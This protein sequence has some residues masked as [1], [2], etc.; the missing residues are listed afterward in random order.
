MVSSPNEHSA[1]C[2]SEL[3]KLGSRQTR[4]SLPLIRSCK[5]SGSRARTSLSRTAAREMAA[6]ARTTSLSR[7]TAQTETATRRAPNCST[8]PRGRFQKKSSTGVRAYF[9]PDSPS[10]ASSAKIKKKNLKIVTDN[11]ILVHPSTYR[12][13]EPALYSD[14]S[15]FRSDK[16]FQNF[17]LDLSAGSQTRSIRNNSPQDSYQR[18]IYSNRFVIGQVALE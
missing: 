6:K 3:C 4:K 8:Q 5:D 1:S 13:A 12:V 14:G 7:R 10:L 18:E 2:R 15:K 16:P 9:D 11:N 17:K